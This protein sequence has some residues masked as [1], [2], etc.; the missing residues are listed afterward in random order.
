MSIL[1]KNYMRL[2][3]RLQKQLKIT[4]SRNGDG[5]LKLETRCARLRF[6]KM[7]K[8]SRTIN[9]LIKRA[10]MKVKKIEKGKSWKKRQKCGKKTSNLQKK[11]ISMRWPHLSLWKIKLSYV[12]I[13][14]VQAAK[15]VLLLTVSHGC[16]AF[17]TAWKAKLASEA[18]KRTRSM[19]QLV[20]CQKIRHRTAK[21]W[22]TPMV[23]QCSSRTYLMALRC[24]FIRA[25]LNEKISS[26]RTEALARKQ[27]L[28][29]ANWWERDPWIKLSEDSP[30]QRLISLHHVKR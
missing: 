11:L 10:S 15:E 7:T 6:S 16:P 17:L 1:R 9:T 23:S 12:T 19:G 30:L 25:P 13:E 8:W 27:C 2:S 21:L 26:Q 5:K 24:Y 29:R 18:R 14:V 22:F 28:I 4:G 3:K 20:K